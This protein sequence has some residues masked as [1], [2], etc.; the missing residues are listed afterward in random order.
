MEEGR[1]DQ[2]ALARHYLGVNRPDRALLALEQLAD[3]GLEEPGYWEIRTA[4]AFDLHR[5]DEAA[6]VGRRGLMVDP[7]NVLLL[8]LVALSELE[9]GNARAAESAID[10][11]LEAAPHDPVLLAHRALIVAHLNRFD[12]AEQCVAE[13]LRIAPQLPLGLRVRAQIAVLRGDDGAAGVYAQDLLA[14]EPNSSFAHIVQANAATKRKRHR[15]AVRHLE[16]AARLNPTQPRIAEA[17]QAS[18]VNANPL[19]APVRP[20]WRFGRWRAWLVY[21]FLLALLAALHQTTLRLVVILVWVTIV[22]LSRVGPRVL[23][24]WYGRRRGVN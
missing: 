15:H 8:D 24:R 16:Q 20:I 9:L 5:W 11:A 19:L 18:R 10:F 21:L 12:E 4:A 17:L 3:G 22:I 1:R 2:L 7:E 23:R 14:V 13:A 6:A